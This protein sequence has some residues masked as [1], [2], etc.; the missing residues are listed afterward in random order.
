MTAHAI[1]KP[2]LAGIE[3][4][5]EGMQPQEQAELWMAL[6]DRMKVDWHQMTLQEKKAGRWIGCG[7]GGFL[8]G[9]EESVWTGLRGDYVALCVVVAAER[10]GATLRC[11]WCLRTAGVDGGRSSISADELG[12]SSILDCIWPTRAPRSATPGPG[13]AG[14]HVYH[15]RD[16]YIL[17]HFPPYSDA[18]ASGRGDDE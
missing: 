18:G 6:R 13:Q 3:K 8:S 16:W 2:T 4:R 9:V 15:A 1:S 14:L 17:C 10:P 11:P 12:C 7:R 5:W